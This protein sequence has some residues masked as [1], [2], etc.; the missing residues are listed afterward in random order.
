MAEERI[1]IGI[2]KDFYNITVLDGGE[3]WFFKN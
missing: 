2:A 3:Q 1:Y